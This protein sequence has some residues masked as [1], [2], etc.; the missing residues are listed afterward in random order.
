M[1]KR[2]TAAVVGAGSGGRL[3]IAALAASARYELKAVADLRPEARFA[4]QALAPGIAAYPSH[5]ELLAR[6]PTQVVCV[7][8]WP[9]SHLQVTRAALALPLTGILV[10]KPLAWNAA[11]GRRL[12]EAVRDRGLPIAVPHGLRVAE[13][14][15]QIRERVADGQIGPLALIEIECRGWDILNAGIHWFDFCGLVLGDDRVCQVQA[16]C[17]ASTRTFRDDVQVE[18]EAVVLA[19]TAAGVR[20]LL[21]TGDE[22]RTSVAGKGTV[23]RLVGTAGSIV[24]HAFEPAYRVV[25]PRHPLGLEVRVEP[26]P[27]SGHQR[28]L[29]ALAAQMD[30]GRPD[31]AIAEGSL[32]ALEVCEAAYLSSRWSCA[33]RLPLSGSAPPAPGDWHPGQPYAGSG[34]G[35]DGRQSR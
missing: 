25:S 17:D 26:G 30:A 8:T 3:S 18:T 31:Y 28:H 5:E 13:H 22:V 2:Y 33:V 11:D 10:E 6:C 16:A 29:D 4:T 7:S 35:R 27:G 32:A 1:A 12:V 15:R 20:I 14:V 34:G 21:H 24:F 19:Q 9:P 23:L